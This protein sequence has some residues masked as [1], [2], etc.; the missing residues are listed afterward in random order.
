MYL[1]G[2]QRNGSY[3]KK[4]LTWIPFFNREGTGA[5]KQFSFPDVSCFSFQKSHGHHNRPRATVKNTSCSPTHEMSPLFFFPDTWSSEDYITTSKLICH[6][7]ERLLKQNHWKRGHPPSLSRGRGQLG[8]PA[9]GW[10][11][12]PLP[13]AMPELIHLPAISTWNSLGKT[14]DDAP[15]G[16]IAYLHVPPGQPLFD[17][18]LVFWPLYCPDL[19]PG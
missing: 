4:A 17:L 3:T 7:G 15:S 6:A 14:I 9:G 18:E 16:V 8:T 2:G 12:D 13:G 19:S 11:A 1:G 10:E 5:G